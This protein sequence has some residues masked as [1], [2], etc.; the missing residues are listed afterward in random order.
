M[1]LGSCA[2]TLYALDRAA[3]TP[4]WSYDTRTDGSRAQFHG[5]PLVL[6]KRV[7]IPTDADPQGHLYAFDTA[8]GELLWK[9]AFNRGIATTPLL[10]DGRV[11]AVSAEGEI[12][13]VDPNR[14]AVVWRRS[15]GATTLSPA[16]AGTRIFVADNKNKVVALDAA[17][18]ATIWQ[19]TVSGRP[20]TA[21][22]VVGKSV[23]LGTQDNSLNWLALDSGDVK[24]RIHLDGMPYGTP[25]LAAPLLYV[26]AKGDLLALDAESGAIRWKQQTPRE[27]T[28][29]RPL[30]AGATIIAGTEEKTLCAFDR[31][32]GET[33]WC[34]DVG[35]ISRGLGI[36]NDGVLYVGSLSGVVQAFRPEP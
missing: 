24:R 11:I 14:G 31:A 22:V 5:E 18:G 8:S 23:V 35:Q 3:G 32:T 6:G 30:V 7:I 21:L 4:L 2:G 34:R 17:T 25:I 13:A 9:L 26:L 15:I 10:V 12:V 19:T 16:A 27:W 28:T 1:L 36:S 33:R 29:Y 20:N